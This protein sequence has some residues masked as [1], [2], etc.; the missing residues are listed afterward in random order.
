MAKDVQA[1]KAATEFLNAVENKESDDKLKSILDKNPKLLESKEFAKKVFPKVGNKKNMG[2]VN[3]DKMVETVKRVKGLAENGTI[4][5]E[6]LN[7]F[8]EIKHPMTKETFATFTAKQAVAACDKANTARPELPEA[9]RNVFKKHQSD[10]TSKLE[11][12]KNLGVSLEADGNGLTID[13][14]SKAGNIK[15]EDGI[16]PAISGKPLANAQSSAE[17]QNQLQ[18]TPLQ[19]N[20][21][22]NE[23]GLEIGGEDKKEALKVKVEEKPVKINVQPKKKTE[24]EDINEATVEDAPEDDKSKNDFNGDKI[25]EQDII[26]YMY[27]EW[28]LAA[29]SYGLNKVVSKACDGVDYLCDRSNKQMKRLKREKEEK[30]QDKVGGFKKNGEY[31]LGEAVTN[32]KNNYAE[33]KNK[34]FAMWKDIAANLGKTPQTWTALNPENPKDKK[35]I[36]MVNKEYKQNPQACIDKVNT[37]IKNYDKTEK[38]AATIYG[39]GAEMAAVEMA[40]E[41]MD[42]GRLSRAAKFKYNLG[43]LSAADID[44][45]LSKKAAEKAREIQETIEAANLAIELKAAREGITDKEAIKTKQAEFTAAYLSTLAK[46]TIDCKTKLSND[47]DKGNFNYARY[48]NNDKMLDS[49]VSIE[50]IQS[51][52]SL[53][54]LTNLDKLG[55]AILAKTHKK[56]VSYDLKSDAQERF[57]ASALEGISSQFS[58]KEAGNKYSKEQNQ[59]RKEK[60]S[61]WKEKV[62]NSKNFENVMNNDNH[63]FIKIM[64][65]SQGR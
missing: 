30:R 46:E 2:L 22:A 8:L 6:Q 27:N 4:K 60:L 52:K 1:A 20:V 5:Q 42:N 57:S 9:D 23:D 56:I 62:L 14:I 38:F 48:G 7:S 10:Y 51:Y 40:Y 39:L 49:G 53:K 17:K 34:K 28:F 63:I 15:D 35:F 50:T 24:D 61:Q 16:S 32:L 3:L 12:L 29:V 11:E 45:K 18:Q 13:E 41:G 33:T 31:L 25:K 26:D 21:A 54:K 19:V 36:D 64:N 43:D 37:T 47:L 59:S 55:D 65:Q 44:K 58:Q